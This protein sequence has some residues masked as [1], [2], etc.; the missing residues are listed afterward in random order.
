MV[1]FL[2]LLPAR[3]EARVRVVGPGEEYT[4]I[5]WAY[6]QSDEG[7]TILVKDGF[8]RENLIIDRSVTLLSENRHG[9]VIGEGEGTKGIIRIMEESVVI[10][11]FLINTNPLIH[12]I[13]V[14][15]LDPE[16]VASNCIIRNNKV[17]NRKIGI[18]ISPNAEN[19][20]LENNQITGSLE[21]G[22]LSA[23]RGSNVF[24]GNH[25]TRS[26][27][28]GV[29]LPENNDA[30]LTISGDTI[31]RSAR[32]GL[33]IETHG[34]TVR[35]TLIAENGGE[36]IFTSSGRQDLLITD[37]CL[38]RDNQGR[39]IAVENGTNMTIS[40][41]EISGNEFHGLV[42]HDSATAWVSENLIHGNRFNGIMCH[43]AMNCK[44]NTLTANVPH[45]VEVHGSAQLSNNV[46]A[47]NRDF[48]ILVHEGAEHVLLKGNQIAFNLEGG[49]I[50]KAGGS[51][52]GNVL[53]GNRSGIS[54]EAAGTSV[55]I[56]GGNQVINNLEHGILVSGAASITDN[57]IGGN[58]SSG[59]HVMPG[60]HEV[61]IMRNTA[62]RDNSEGIYLGAPAMVVSNQIRHH[63][64]AGIYV[65]EGAD[66][67]LIKGNLISGNKQGLVL[68]PGVSGVRV[69]HCEITFNASGVV[70]LGQSEFRTNT[71]EN[72]SKQGVL[73]L[74]PGI[75]LGR[76]DSSEWGYN[77][78]G[79]NAMWNIENRTGDSIPA[80]YN[81]WNSTDTAFIDSTIRD[82]E[83]DPQ[84]GPVIFLPMLGTDATAMDHSPCPASCGG[85]LALTAIYPSPFT[86]VLFLRFSQD[87][88][89]PVYARIYR[90][91]GVPVRVILNG[92]AF[93]AGEHEL[94]WDGNDSRGRP[95]PAGSYVLELENAL[96][97]IARIV[98][99]LH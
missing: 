4:A 34:V 94:T 97:R 79:N 25:I 24:S 99:K 72:N 37:G 48:G 2:A 82:V 91:D 83:E 10:D 33:A 40:G 39:G 5:K 86:H 44:G 27:S 31:T 85:G 52:T 55:I 29:S 96:H 58:G 9:A 64:E 75:D 63:T 18:L 22:I 90:I 35:G 61:S 57:I 28:D 19:T 92:Q 1:V 76:R 45:G 23:G 15:Q 36:G 7:D 20:T 43:G 89:S 14:G 42:V 84:L 68:R 32:H 74:R 65:D 13:V 6:N 17:M 73:I 77:T 47:E 54:V 69:L 53:E 8:Y 93:H 30:T 38:I 41:N 88:A 67:A 80:S 81:F 66:S 78:L 21:N 3:M 12:G 16:R 11:G 59:I 95:L 98:Q 60:A 50:M 49:L 70:S 87:Q 62:I 56:S 46:V 26:G 71:I 51:V